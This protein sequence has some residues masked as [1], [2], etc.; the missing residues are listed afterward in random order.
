ML[1]LI[2]YPS[3]IFLGLFI[4]QMNIL[5]N[6]S[7]LVSDW[8]I[9][10]LRLLGRPIRVRVYGMCYIPD[11]PLW[12]SDECVAQQNICHGL[13]KL[14]SY[15]VTA[16]SV[17]VMREIIRVKKC[18]LGVCGIDVCS[19]NACIEVFNWFHINLHL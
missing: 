17:S 4:V 19:V 15:N 13:I 10:S 14:I 7:V 12:T 2:L 5:V 8:L 3:K 9:S 16:A 6:S 18:N 1:I 11:A